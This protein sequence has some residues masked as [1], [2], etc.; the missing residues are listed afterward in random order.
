LLEFSHSLHALDRIGEGI[1][2][3]DADGRFTY[4]NRTAQ[5][6][7]PAL[8]G[9]SGTDLHGTVIWDA[10]PSFGL[11]PT[12]TALRRA[13][14]DGL[15]V[16][17]PV[18]DPVSGLMLELRAFPSADGVSV[19][20]IQPSGQPEGALLDAL[21]DLYLA[22]DD[23]WRLT[24]LNARAGEYLRFLGRNRDELLGQSV[25]EVIPGLSGSRFQ[26][27]AFRAVV[28]QREVEFESFFA[29]MN[30]WF[31]VRLTPTNRGI[32]ACARDVTT[33]YMT[34]SADAVPLP[35]SVETQEQN[36][37]FRSLVESIDDVVFQLDTEQRCVNLFGRWLEREGFL[38]EQFIGR[39]TREILG[40]TE[41]PVHERANQRAL[42][43]ET[44]T[45]EW[46]LL[47][48]RGPRHVLN[49]L[50]PLRDPNGTITG[51]VGVGRDITA[52]IEAEQQVRQAQKMEAVGRFAG[53]VAHDLNNMVMVIM[54]FSDFLLATL[55][56]SDPRWADADEIRKAAERAMQL[57]RQLL[58]FG[59]QQVVA[60][61]VVDLNAV[62]SG[63]ERMLRPLLGEDMILSTDLAPALGGIEADY[64]QM[65]QIVMNLTLNARDAMG[66]GGRLT[67]E[68]RDLEFPD[69][70]AVQHLGIPIPGGS[71]VMLVVSDTG[72]GMTPEVKSHLF[73][74]FFST[75]LITQ[76]TGLGLATVYGIV[77]Q[78]GGYIWVESE[79]GIGTTFKI[80]FPRVSPDQEIV[81]VIEPSFI[82]ATGTETILLIED[83]EAVR[84]LASRVLT[85]QGYLVLEASNGKEGLH[86]AEQAGNE[87]DLVLT[88]MIM[89]EMSGLEA[90]ARISK[91]LPDTRIMYMSGYSEADKLQR[92]ISELPQ[93]FLQKPFSAESL[94]VSVRRTLD[95]QA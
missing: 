13:V 7:L 77:A 14:E 46:V 65:E 59:R 90:A 76:N 75:K 18:R 19:L 22:C 85:E 94:S 69:H 5:H 26:A 2:A 25:W 95:R 28:E 12:A 67:L 91:I 41:A 66:S 89:P 82:P 61:T 40:P 32:I 47:T 60:R 53:G 31:S 68:T 34:R 83:E 57:T 17:H 52:R 51:I 37:R 23:E 84:T 81:E 43:G 16:V 21:S 36:R 8:I 62:V 11:T 45:Y 87:I 15:P 74:P 33:R 30:R 88:D 1:F 4:L 54:G 78:S 49:T 39:T 29:P 6:L 92:G 10:S 56:R 73:E 38:S 48:A 70:H 24:M 20:L 71:Y 50:S 44:V 42:A 9:A 93:P 79:L 55:D 63:M 80:C 58:G 64:G 3:L 86:V 27:E 35:E 72:H